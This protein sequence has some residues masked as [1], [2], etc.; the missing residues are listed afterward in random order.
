MKNIARMAASVLLLI[1]LIAG[2]TSDKNNEPSGFTVSGTL[3]NAKDIK[4]VS[5][6]ELTPGGLVQIDTASVS[7]D[8]T[9]S[10]NGKLPE[11][12]F[13]VLR[14]TKGDVLL[15][16][17]TNSQLKVNVDV[18]DLST[19]TVEGSKEN[20]EL[21]GLYQ[22]NDRF[23]KR[24]EE[25]NQRFSGVTKETFTPQIEI[26]VQQAFDS[27]RNDHHKAVRE[28]IAPLNSLVP[29]F[30][31]NFLMPEPDLELLS[32]IDGKLFSKYS[33]SKYAIQIHQKVESLR[34]TAAGSLA[35]DIVLNDPFGKTVSLSSFRGKIVLIDFWASWCGPCRKENPNNVALYNKYKGA[36]F[37]IF[38]V[39]LD[40]NREDW[41]AAINKD[42]LLW[43]HG[44]DLMKWNSPVVGLYQIEGIPHTVLVD[45]E[46]KIIAKGLRGEDLGAKLKEI[47]GF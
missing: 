19:Y 42:H 26:Q 20:E 39:S 18:N 34:K 9:F 28:Y 17:D 23:M 15:L 8:G 38:G 43:P 27:L 30:A 45:K 40:D 4:E 47:F 11:K 21:K 3:R 5:I 41:I 29:Y 10:L 33:Q 32:E 22:V 12:T 35:P 2:C 36:G 14:F 25:I 46:G 16:V 6:Q 13:C 24:S 37:E 44:S 7:T 1:N 31:V